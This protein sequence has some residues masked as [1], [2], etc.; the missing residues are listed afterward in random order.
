MAGRPAMFKTVKEIE[1]KIED[2]FDSLK[3]VVDNIEQSKPATITGLAYHLGFSDRAS[4]YDYKDKPEFTHT[5]KRARFYIE[6]LYESGLHTKASTGCIFALKNFGWK[7][8]VEVD[9]INH[10]IDIELSDEE[11]AEAINK[12]KTRFSEFDDYSRD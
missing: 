6:S 11:K 10:N 2:Y 5:I 3:Y 1:K 4:F 12:I 8:K 7:D 9:N